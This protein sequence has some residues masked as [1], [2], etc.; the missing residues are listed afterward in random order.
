MY[1]AGTS[2]LLFVPSMCG[3]GGN[4]LLELCLGLAT[5]LLPVALFLYFAFTKAFAPNAEQ[6]EEEKKR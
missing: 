5:G 6:T 1:Y 2:A 3:I 4:D